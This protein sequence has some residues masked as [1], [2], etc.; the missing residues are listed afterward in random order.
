MATRRFTQP[1][2]WIGIILLQLIMTQVTT[3]ILSMLFPG[4]DAFPLNYP[5]LFVAVL[6]VAFSLGV[7]LPGWLALNKG[8][9]PGEPKYV[10]RLVGALIGAYIPLIVG[11]IVFQRLE[12]GN[13][14]FLISMLVS[15]F[16][17]YLPGWIKA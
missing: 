2:I 17:F 14:F 5:V 15:I 16:G 8:W 9:L 10:Q 12:P 7:F 11:L 6:G 1:F 13:P 3:F 4:G